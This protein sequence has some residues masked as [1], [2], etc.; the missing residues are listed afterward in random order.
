MRSLQMK[1]G[2]EMATS[3]INKNGGVNVNGKKKKIKLI[4]KDN[5]TSTS[6]SA[7]VA[8]QLANNDKVSA[9]IGTA[10]TN[11][12]IAHNANDPRHPT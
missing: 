9:I 3:E 1:Q 2:V 11:A 8:A 4:I 10:T 6:T 12:A 7:S 5:K